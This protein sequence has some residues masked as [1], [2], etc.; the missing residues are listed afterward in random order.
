MNRYYILFTAVLT[1]AAPAMAADAYDSG[2]SS[3]V[4]EPVEAPHSSKVQEKLAQQARSPAP[5]KGELALELYV[6]SQARIAETFR[7]PVPD[8]MTEDTLGN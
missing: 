3:G 1:G 6:D 4:I 7:R 2:F 5:E 8:Q